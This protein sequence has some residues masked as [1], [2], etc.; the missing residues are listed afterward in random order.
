MTSE[1]SKSIN[2]LNIKS[3]L[4]LRFGQ[5]HSSGEFLKHNVFGI[6]T[7]GRYWELVLNLIF[8]IIYNYIQYIN[9]T[10]SIN[11]D[12]PVY[13][14]VLDFHPSS[15]I[16]HNGKKHTKRLEGCKGLKCITQKTIK[17]YVLR[18]RYIFVLDFHPSSQIRQNGKKQ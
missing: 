13:I 6:F 14:F 18:V 4:L 17:L 7:L 12:T 3:R 1:P 11:R 16:R 8:R 15:Q 9:V 10:S 2:F 5:I